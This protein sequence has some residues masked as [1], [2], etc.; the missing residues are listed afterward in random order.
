MLKSKLPTK[1]LDMNRHL[2]QSTNSHETVNMS[3][4][5]QKLE[6]CNG[7]GSTKLH[8]HLQQS[9]LK[10]QGFGINPDSKQVVVALVSSFT[11]N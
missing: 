2:A 7:E 4:F 1:Y 5:L 6:H 10:V 9:R 3:R 8:I 11:K